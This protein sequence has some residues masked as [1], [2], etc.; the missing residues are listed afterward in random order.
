[1]NTD[2]ELVRGGAEFRRRFLDFLGAQIEPTYRVTLRAYERALRSRNALLKASQ[3]NLRALAAY[4][5][6]LV[7]HGA[8]LSRMRAGLVARL[9]PFV[10]AAHQEVS[11]RQETAELAFAPGNTGDFAAELHASR[12]QELRLRQTVVGPHRDDI[13]LLV[14][15]MPAAQYASEGQQRTIALAMKIGQARVFAAEGGAP[16]LLLIDD[17]FGE[18]D[19]SRRNRLL[20]ALPAESQKL[21][22]ATNMDWKENALDWPVF[23]L[24]DGILRAA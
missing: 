1:A 5:A 12:A 14:D 13:A 3:P 18:L 7:E 17:I 8:I 9:T 10:L 21:V 6:P 23:Q 16:P 4:D 20:D 24:A 11:G 22:T 2:I 19:P 15:G